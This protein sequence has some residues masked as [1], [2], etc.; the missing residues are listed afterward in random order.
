MHLS[1]NV[2]SQ[3]VP[4]AAPPPREEEPVAPVA[5][6]PVAMSLPAHTPSDST[7]PRYGRKSHVA[8]FSGAAVAGAGLFTFAIGAVELVSTDRASRAERGPAQATAGITMGAG[9]AMLAVGVPL[10][11]Y[12]AQR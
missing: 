2:W 10:V 12:G 1:S 11:L 9:A 6:P 7:T 8:I 5:A 3:E 4:S